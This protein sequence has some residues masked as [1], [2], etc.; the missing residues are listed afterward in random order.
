MGKIAVI[1][2][3]HGNIEALKATLVSIKSFNVDFI[4]CLG[5]II[6]KGPYVDEVIDICRHECKHIVKGNWED[7]ILTKTNTPKFNWY[8]NKL[9]SDNK[10]FLES[11]PQ[12]LDIRLQGVPFR[13][14]HASPHCLHMR[15][16]NDNPDRFNFLFETKPE[17]RDVFLPRIVCYGDIHIQYIERTNNK[18]IVNTGSVGNPHDGCNASYSIIEYRDNDFFISSIKVEYRIKSFIEKIKKTNVPEKDGFIKE[19]LTG[20]YRYA[21]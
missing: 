3:I 15:I 12:V 8:R 20:R 9:S 13:F 6:G 18:T 17:I 11:L 16:Y 4:V 19:L 10:I 2:D 1:S 7:L 21:K 14:F 5:D